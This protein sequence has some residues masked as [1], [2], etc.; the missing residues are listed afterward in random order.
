MDEYGRNANGEIIHRDEDGAEYVIDEAGNRRPPMKTSE[1]EISSSGFLS[2][3]SS[4][5]HCGLCGRL[6]CSGGC[7]K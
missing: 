1:V 3:D 7:F 6:D 2:Y 4:K 5:G